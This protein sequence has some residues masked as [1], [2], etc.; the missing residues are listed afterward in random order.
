MASGPQL[1]YG[2]LHLVI[3]KQIFP[4]RAATRW[5]TLP[6]RQHILHPWRY[7]KSARPRLWAVSWTCSVLWLNRLTQ[8]FPPVSTVLWF[9]V[10]AVHLTGS[11][12][13]Q[14]TFPHQSHML[15]FDEIT[16]DAPLGFHQ[17]QVQLN[18]SLL[19]FLL[20]DS[21]RCNYALKFILCCAITKFPRNNLVTVEDERC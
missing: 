14:V 12:L 5:N 4:R 2:Q 1:Q 19:Y 21:C 3:R 10:S 17:I 20:N 16:T 15:S 8:R 13:L 11:D 6:E 18:S 7:P 9:C